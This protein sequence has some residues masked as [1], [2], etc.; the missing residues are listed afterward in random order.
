MLYSFGLS[1]FEADLLTGSKFLGVANYTNLF[2]DPLFLKSLKVTATY[3]FVSVPLGVI[4]ALG[5][6]MLLN[7]KIVGL[8]VWRTVYY[9]PSLISGVAVSVL[10]L[11]IFNPRM[12]LINGLLA[13]FG[14]KGPAWIFDSNWA[15]PSLIIMS[16]WGVGATMLLYLAGL[17]GIP[18]ELYEAAEIDGAGKVRKFVNIT[19]PMLTPTIFFNSLIGL[20]A[21]FQLFTQA[22]VMT[23][24]GPN[25]ATL[26][27][28]LFLYRKA[29]QQTRFGYASAVAWILFAI[30][31]VFTVLYVRFSDRWVFYAGQENN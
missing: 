9:M 11:Q 22:M 17:Q 19:I 27:M 8:S 26:T 18:T 7:Q 1:F 29:F 12:G 16:L 15:L 10:W 23:G 13:R 14:I 3:A 31:I 20:I 24:G 5:V 21:A 6:A 28:V 30:I 4:V 25:N 2:H